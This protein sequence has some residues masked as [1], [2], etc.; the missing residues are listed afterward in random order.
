[1]SDSE[2]YLSAFSATNDTAEAD[3]RLSKARIAS[4]F[5]DRS[6]AVG[7]LPTVFKPHLCRFTS[8]ASGPALFLVRC[9][10]IISR[11]YNFWN[12]WTRC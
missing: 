1:M 6:T 4:S 11:I 5:S 10:S 7:H 3:R 12:F 2:V 9:L 8:A